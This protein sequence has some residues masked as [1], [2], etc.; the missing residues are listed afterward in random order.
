MRAFTVANE[1]VAVVALGSN[2]LP[3]G[4]TTAGTFETNDGDLMDFLANFLH[5]Y[6]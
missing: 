1:A 2:F 5:M 3:L 4:L 6:I